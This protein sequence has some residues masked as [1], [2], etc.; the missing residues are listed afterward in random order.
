VEPHYP[1]GDIR[2]YPAVTDSITSTFPHQKANNA[3]RGEWR[4]GELCLRS[5]LF[6]LGRVEYDLDPV[7]N[8][9]RLK[10]H[11]HQALEWLSDAATDALL[12]D[13]HAYEL[14]IFPAGHEPFVTVANLEDDH[15][16]GIWNATDACYGVVDLVRIAS[17]RGEVLLATKFSTAKD[18]VLTYQVGS[19]LTGTEPETEAAIW[20]R[21]DA[22]PILRP[23]QA[24]ITWG[25]LRNASPELSGYL[26]RAVG[27][28]RDGKEHLVL[29]GFPLSRVVGQPADRMHWQTL[30]LPVL[31][32]SET[33]TP[34]F[35][36]GSPQGV[37]QGDLMEGL[38]S[39]ERLNWQAAE[40]WSKQQ[41]NARGVFADDLTSQSV[42]IIGAGAIG[43]HLANLLARGGVD[44]FLVIDDDKLEYG[45]LCRHTL[46][47]N[48]IG[49]SKAHVT[50]VQLS[51]IRANLEADSLNAS[52]PEGL[53]AELQKKLAGSTLVVDCSGSDETLLELSKFA[54]ERETLFCSVAV[55]YYAKRI[56]VY[57]ARGLTFPFSD[58]Q[59]AVAPWLAK[60]ME[61]FAHVEPERE[62]AGCW[63]ISFPARV[64][65]IA[66]AASMAVRTLDNWG[67]E[68]FADS[69]LHVFEQGLHGVVKVHPGNAGAT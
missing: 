30:R 18:I 31:S 1:W 12:R 37:W 48:L 5:P 8:P 45:N 38:K 59:T 58:F 16:F 10:W 60:D 24:P 41:A 14:P 55:G 7:G 19:W 23:H 11:F 56:Y 32:A 36:P 43:S 17:Q 28:L 44:K 65:E 47:M 22:V 62:S 27:I 53:D 20:V 66:V 13:G 25:E 64:D 34:G 3:E 33:F 40:N 54:W 69:G 57:L 26:Q 51:S 46:G 6:S 68:G 50:A 39:S 21:L 67:R 61:D 4:S 2:F 63:H 52:F 9:L 49:R 35:R 29:I 42:A 15:T